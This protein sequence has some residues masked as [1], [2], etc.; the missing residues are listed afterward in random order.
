M[1]YHLL[2]FI[3]VLFTE[4][5]VSAQIY[6]TTQGGTAQRTTSVGG[7]AQFEASAPL[8]TYTGKSDQLQGNIN[9]DTDTVAFVL[10]A[11]SIKTGIEKRD[12]NMYE[13]LQ[14]KKNP[15]IT[16]KGKLISNFD[17][18]KSEP[19]AIKVKGDF[20]LAGITRTVT[21]KGSLKNI[22]EGIQLKAAWSLMITDYNLERPSIAFFKVEDQHDLSSDAVLFKQ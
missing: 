1:H 15:E 8:H 7:H 6:T 14:V 12:E 20:T 22:E 11:K 4:C 5:P 21:I 19:Q 3:L 10:P 9:F 13:L 16:F 2:A 17:P 18:E